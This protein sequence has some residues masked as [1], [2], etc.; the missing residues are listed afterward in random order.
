MQD[1]MIKISE[2]GI[3]AARTFA[4]EIFADGRVIAQGSLT[5]VQS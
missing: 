2:A 5:P 1:I 4:Y 3:A